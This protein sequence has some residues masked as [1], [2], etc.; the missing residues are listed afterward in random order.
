MKKLFH[1]IFMGLFAV[2][3]F[4]FT[5]C[6]EGLNLQEDSDRNFSFS[7]MYS[8]MKSMQEEIDQLKKINISFTTIMDK[9]AALINS[10]TN[11][12]SASSDNLSSMINDN[13]ALITGLQTT[14][15]TQGTAIT[16]L[17]TTTNS[18]ATEIKDLQDTTSS[19]A[20]SIETLQIE[21]NSHAASIGSLEESVKV[22]D[23]V[24]EM[25]APVGTIIAW[26]KNMSSTPNLPGTWVECN[27][28]TITDADSVYYGMNTQ[29]LNGEGRFLRGG[30]TSG[31]YQEDTTAR[32]GLTVQVGGSHY[33]DI[34]TYHDDWNEDDKSPL[35]K[36]S[37]ADDSP[38]ESD[39]QLTHQ[40]D[41]GG[42]HSH[43]LLGDYET[44][45][46]NMS[47]VWIMRIK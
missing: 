46:I 36:P 18:Q 14:T 43:I 27:G 38:N 15:G 23:V 41:S 20:T 21:S 29:N 13:T 10:L 32:N 16:N 40:T 1:S 42:N 34:Y 3:V 17:Q 6:E 45:P 19:Q 28:Q 24:S 47:V 30:S 5:G 9:Q 35:T 2:T 7:D 22:I 33:H 31:I 44:R 26:Q 25:S 39:R 12:Q 4:A 37:W 11:D 8:K